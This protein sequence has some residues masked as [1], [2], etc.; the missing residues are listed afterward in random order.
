MNGLTINWTEEMIDRVR[1]EII[2]QKEVP[3][4]CDRAWPGARATPVPDVAL[5]RSAVAGRLAFCLA[6]AAGP[7]ISSAEP[8]PRS[9][10]RQIQGGLPQRG[11]S[12]ECL[13]LATMSLD[14][15]G[16]GRAHGCPGGIPPATR[17]L[18][19]SRAGSREPLTDE[20]RRTPHTVDRTVPSGHRNMRGRAIP[21]LL[22]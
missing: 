9:P 3:H 11:H 16:G 1:G 21:V 15:T 5:P 19:P 18:S 4:G 22:G 13:Y 10:G 6:P 20:N 12:P 17:P 8:A 7:G 2:D 14:S